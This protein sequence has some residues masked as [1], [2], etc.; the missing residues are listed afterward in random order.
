MWGESSDITPPEV[1][2]LSQNR[3]KISRVVGFD[4]TVVTFQA[5]EDFQAYQVRLVP[6]PASTITEGALVESGG[7]ALANEVFQVTIT[8]DEL[9]NVGAVEGNNI[10]KIFVQ[11]LAGNWSDP[12]VVTMLSAGT[13]LSANTILVSAGLQ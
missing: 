7:S 11:D 1:T 5:N 6:S 12:G 8:D 3:T 13:L 9:I 2:F 4:A 10:L